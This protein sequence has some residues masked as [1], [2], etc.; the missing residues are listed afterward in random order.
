MVKVG[1]I[2]YLLLNFAL[3]CKECQHWIKSGIFLGIESSVIWFQVSIIQTIKKYL[4]SNLKYLDF[5]FSNFQK[6]KCLTRTYTYIKNKSS[7]TFFY[8]NKFGWNI[9]IWEISVFFYGVL[10]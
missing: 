2:F 8:F 3:H 7:T 9:L 6:T 5:Y 4:K 1:F 10:R